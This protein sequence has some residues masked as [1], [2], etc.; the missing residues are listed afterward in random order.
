MFRKQ[1]I[2]NY[3]SGNQPDFVIGHSSSMFIKPTLVV[4]LLL[5]VL[6]GIFSVTDY[7]L[8]SPYIVWIFVV[9]GILLL[10]KYT[11]DFLNFYLDCLVISPAGMT[12]FMREGV[13]EYKTDYFERHTIE[14]ISH[15]QNSFRDKLF[16]K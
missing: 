14:T 5:F 1:I 15:T 3:I 7:Y 2:K 4:I 8:D 10:I 6:Y 9:L 16:D 13:F 11:I 12:L